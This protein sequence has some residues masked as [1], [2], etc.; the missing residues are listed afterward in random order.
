MTKKDFKASVNPAT[1]FI[2]TQAEPEAPAPKPVKVEKPKAPMPETKPAKAPKKEDSKDSK[3]TKSKRLNLLIQPSVLE[4]FNKVAFMER[5]SMN[6]LINTMIK[7]YC[8][9]H[10]EEIETYNKY[11]KGE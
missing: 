11:F 5:T 8:D 10:R 1:L 3:E 9:A 4:D 6:D 7:G 2:N